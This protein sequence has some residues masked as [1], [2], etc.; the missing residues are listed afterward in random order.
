MAVVVDFLYSDGHEP[1]VEVSNSIKDLGLVPLDHPYITSYFIAMPS[2]IKGAGFIICPFP[3]Q[4][5]QRG[6]YMPSALIGCP[7]CVSADSNYTAR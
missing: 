6:T 3:Q 7:L 2:L 4:P 5:A 1:S